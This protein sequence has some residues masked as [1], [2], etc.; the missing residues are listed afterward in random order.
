MTESRHILRLRR[1]C[2]EFSPYSLNFPLIHE[3]GV[4]WLNMRRNE[5]TLK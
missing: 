2:Y 5:F 3:N 4:K 1:L